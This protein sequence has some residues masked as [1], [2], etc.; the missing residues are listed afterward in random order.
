MQIYACQHAKPLKI[1]HFTQSQAIKE[2]AI[3]AE[4]KPS[5]GKVKQG[6]QSLE[7]SKIIPLGLEWTKIESGEEQGKGTNGKAKK[8]NDALGNPFPIHKG[9]NQRAR[10]SIA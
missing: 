7:A 6:K 9:N 1:R 3:S 10:D 2:I 4:I 5:N 8:S